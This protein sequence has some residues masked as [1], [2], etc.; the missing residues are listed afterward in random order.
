MHA[1][2]SIG[3][4]SRAHSTP[5]CHFSA[6]MPSTSCI[7]EH[8]DSTKTA[9]TTTTTTIFGEPH[10]YRP[11]KCVQPTS[12][13]KPHHRYFL[14]ATTIPTK[15]DQPTSSKESFRPVA[16]TTTSA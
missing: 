8:Y 7:I 6:A 15:R 5:T 12:S 4:I 13:I 16:A 10:C 11:A 3:P 9:A 2:L 1:I 14:A